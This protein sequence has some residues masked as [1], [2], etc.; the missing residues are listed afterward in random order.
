MVVLE[1]K[2]ADRGFSA[3]ESFWMFCSAVSM[4]VR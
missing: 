3:A 1:A 4:A 2:R